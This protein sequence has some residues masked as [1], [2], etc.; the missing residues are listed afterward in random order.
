[1][2][3]QLAG[4][5]TWYQFDPPPGPGVQLGDANATGNFNLQTMVDNYETLV[6]DM[7]CKF[8]FAVSH[9]RA[10]HLRYGPDSSA[11]LSPSCTGLTATNGFPSLGSSERRA[12]SGATTVL[13]SMTPGAF[14]GYV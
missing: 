5:E 8:G 14:F 1:M 2:E 4:L 9:L 13:R 7:S 11:P 12:S 3:L 6:R 10:S